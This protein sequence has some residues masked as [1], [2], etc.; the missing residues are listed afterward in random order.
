[1]AVADKADA[2]FMGGSGGHLTALIDWSLAQLHPGGRLVMT[3][4][5][6]ENLHSALGHLQQ[7]GIHEV[8][9]QQL[10]V[11][12]LA[13]LGSGHYFKPHNPVFVIACQKE[14]NH[15]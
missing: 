4:I 6:Q 13:T 14:E 8:D 1:L 5:L 3:F 15:G 7:C 2:I 10:A 9:C 12:T 11:S